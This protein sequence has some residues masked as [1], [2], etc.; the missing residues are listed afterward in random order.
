LAGSTQLFSWT[1]SVN[2]G[3][4]TVNYWLDA[5]TSTSENFYYQSGNLGTATSVTAMNLPVWVINPNSPPQVYMTLWNLIGG[6]WIPSPAVVYN[7]PLAV[8]GFE[9]DIGDWAP[10]STTI[11]TASGGG[12]LQ[13]AAASGGYYGEVHNID[14]D[15]CGAGCGF[16]D[17]GYSYFGFATQPVYPGDFSQ[18]IK[19]YVNANWPGAL[20]GGPGVWIDETPGSPS[21]NYGGEHN[22]R[23]TPTGTSVGISADGGGTFATITTSGWY[24]FQMTFQKGAQPTDLVTT[25]MNVFDPSGHL[26]GTT[27]VV[28]NSPGGPLYSQDL[29][30]P[31]YVWITVWPNGWAGDVLGI[32]DVR[33]DLL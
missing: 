22:F 5:G 11:R 29:M 6:N 9:A 24:N 16:G 3:C 30:G 7:R 28:S 4:G 13:L 1:P 27:S 17:S 26:V 18:S 19:M 14:D 20:Y 15:Y 33:A 21:G 32:D 2:P 23:L 25:I 8:Q 31:G 10:P 12:N